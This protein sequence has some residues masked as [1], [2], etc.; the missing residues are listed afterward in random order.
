MS[1]LTA[2]LSSSDLILHKSN[3]NKLDYLYEISIEQEAVNP[4]S[5]PLIN[6]YSAF[7][8]QAFSLLRV[9]KYLIKHHPKGVRE[10]IQASKVDQH[11][12]LATKKK[13]FI[14]LFIPPNFLSQWKQ[15]GFTHIYFG[16]IRFSLS[17]H[18][19]KGLRM[20]A[21]IALLDTRFKKYQH[22]CIAIV[23]TTLDAGTVFI[24]LFPNFNTS[25][26]YVPFT[27]ENSNTINNRNS[28]QP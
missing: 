27:N 1:S 4:T 5:L 13:Q 23:E 6:P 25:S 7:G 10:Y 11:H 21:R 16:A 22:A 9:I 3:S 8:K 24:T 14:P 15:Q 12:I 28:L 20:V 19:R 26:T 18:E 17:L 2:S